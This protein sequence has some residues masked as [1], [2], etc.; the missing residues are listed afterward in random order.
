MKTLPSHLKTL[1]GSSLLQRGQIDCVCLRVSPFV[2]PS[3]FRLV[4]VVLAKLASNQ[5]PLSQ[6]VI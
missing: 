6:V 4:P 5:V 3:G 1:A 2:S